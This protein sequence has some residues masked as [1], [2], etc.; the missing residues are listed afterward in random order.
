M[1]LFN[2]YQAVALY[3]ATLFF[4]EWLNNNGFQALSIVVGIGE[5]IGFILL[6]LAINESPKNV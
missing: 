3:T 2:C 4:I 6:G 5:I 1:K